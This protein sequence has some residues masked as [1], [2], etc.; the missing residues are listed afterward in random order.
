VIGAVL[1]LLAHGTLHPMAA[2]LLAWSAGWFIASAFLQL[3]RLLAR[4]HRSRKP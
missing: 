2:F 1:L 4:V 3:Q